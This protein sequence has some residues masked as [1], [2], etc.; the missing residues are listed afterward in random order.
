MIVD[1]I[2]NL[3]KYATL[4]P[5]FAD[6]IGFLKENNLNELAEGKHSIKE[7]EL[8]VNVQTAHGKPKD[9]AVVETHRAMLDIQMPLDQVETYG[10]IPLKDLPSV[11]YDAEKDL[12]L[13]PGVKARYFVTCKP[14]E[15]VIFFPQ[16]GHAP[17]ICNSDIHKAIFKVKA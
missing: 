11:G 8:F 14:G 10:Y 17:C 16:D 3:G 7:G 5:L 2:D 12:T 4:N 15:F 6:V 9:Q 13:Y 1:T